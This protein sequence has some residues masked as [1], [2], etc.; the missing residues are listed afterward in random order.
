MG[1]ESTKAQ[2]WTEGGHRPQDEG[3]PDRVWHDL[4]RSVWA[5]AVSFGLH[6]WVGELAM[7]IHGRT[8]RR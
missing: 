6:F 5:F 2:G 1:D 4:A 8:K 7:T 3:V